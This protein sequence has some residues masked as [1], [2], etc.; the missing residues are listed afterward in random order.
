MTRN[1]CKILHL[2]FLFTFFTLAGCKSRTNTSSGKALTNLHIKTKPVDLTRYEATDEELARVKSEFPNDYEYAER[3][4]KK[5]KLIGKVKTEE[6]VALRLYT[7][8]TYSELNGALRAQDPSSLPQYAN[9]IK[10]AA[11]GLNHIPA[12]TCIAK[13]G[14]SG[15]SDA[16]IDI[17][18]NKRRFKE[19]GFTS[20]SY[21]GP[22][23]SG[24]IEFTIKSD[25]C[26]KIDW[27]SAVESEKEALFPPGSEFIVETAEFSETQEGVTKFIKGVVELT[28]TMDPDP[29]GEP[30]TI[31]TEPDPGNDKFKKKEI[32][33]KTFKSMNSPELSIYLDSGS[34]LTI[35]KREA[36]IYG[37][38]SLFGDTITLMPNDSSIFGLPVGTPILLR[39]INPYKL[40]WIDPNNPKHILDTFTSEKSS[41]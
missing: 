40:E 28:H 36:S 41:P 5:I 2:I 25:H 24:K 27:L 33:E 7:G 30:P 8:S 1:T 39:G 21:G 14:V 9:T 12:E 38:W 18:K 29:A 26:R 31:S 4:V 37:Y 17:L 15:L 3:D 11:S 22:G 32:L 16:A 10:A 6:A 20:T 35:R 34:R 13:R 23:F 19:A